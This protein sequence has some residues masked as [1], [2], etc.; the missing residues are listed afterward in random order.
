MGI[1]GNEMV[2]RRVSFKYKVAAVSAAVS[3]R[4]W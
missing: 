3:S 4:L 2:C 1:R